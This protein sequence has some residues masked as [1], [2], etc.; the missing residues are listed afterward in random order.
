MKEKLKGII[1]GIVI[2]ALLVPTVFAAVNTI[3]KEIFYK[4]IKIILDGAEITPTDANGTYIE[5]FIMD[6]T[7]YLPVR[8]IASALGLDVGWDGN[9]NT[10]KL[11][12]DKGTG[13]VTPDDIAKVGDVVHNNNGIKVTLTE[14]KNLNASNLQYKFL[15]ENLNDEIILIYSDDM[16]VNDFSLDKVIMHEYIQPGKKLEVSLLVQVGKDATPGIDTVEKL[17]INLLASFM[18]DLQ[19]TSV[20]KTITEKIAMKFE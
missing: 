15:I 1:T 19:P 6:G 17:E 10:V 11:S 13:D 9:T 4:N 20:E 8:G 2:G 14:V 12:R 18:K 16:Y 7:T 3:T 5:P